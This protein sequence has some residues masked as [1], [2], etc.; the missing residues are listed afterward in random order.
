METPVAQESAQAAELAAPATVTETPS[1]EL[2]VQQP[3]AAPVESAP[4]QE[5]SL[6]AEPKEVPK[7]TEAPKGPEPSGDPKMLE[8]LKR[9]RKRAQQAEETVRQREQEAANLRGQLEERARQ[10]QAAV[11]PAKPTSTYDGTRPPSVNDFENYDDFM[12]ESIKYD[13]RKENEKVQQENRLKQQ[14]D[15]QK[16]IEREFFARVAK[17]Q[18]EKFPDYDE[19]IR[20]VPITLGS[21][22]LQ[23]IK[24]S[25]VG[26][27]VA[28]HLAKNPSEIT[29]INQMSVASA[30][31][32]IGKLEAK[33][34]TV[35][36]TSKPT[37]KVSQAPEPIKP[38]KEGTSAVAIDYDKMS[39][40]DFM[41]RRRE[42]TTTK[43]ATRTG[44]RVVLKR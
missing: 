20:S 25:E 43:I 13:L 5:N 19:V 8:E 39:M 17:A 33:L 34:T 23:A 24:E 29:R 32:E 22:V 14:Q 41:K 30:V 3:L 21:E 27:E 15:K 9:V 31:R 7:T 40:D 12:K 2:Q 38:V 1:T 42:E 6:A 11:T 16:E 37:I 10:T 18:E 44:S 28:Y 35:V 26:P 4:T 36:P